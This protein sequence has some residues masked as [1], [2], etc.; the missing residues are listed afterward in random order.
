MITHPRVFDDEWTPQELYHREGAVEVLSEAFDPATQGHAA[1]NVIIHGPSGVGKTVLAKHTMGRLE[2]HA[3]VTTGLIEGLGTTT[4]AVLRR[5]VTVAARDTTPPQNA[6]VEDLRWQLRECIEQPLILVLDE[7][8]G[9]P[10]TDALDQL[11]AIEQLSIVA[12]VH[13]ED[14]WL[15]RISDDARQA[16]AVSI[17]LDRYHINELAAILRARAEKG[18]AESVVT[19]TQLEHIADEVAGVA[20]YGI[21]S[22]HAAA[23]LAA[24]RDHWTIQEQD[25]EGSFARARRRIRRLNLRS[26]PVHHHVLYAL[27]RDAGEISARTLHT[28]YDEIADICYRGTDLMPIGKRER[29]NK[30]QKLREYDL[31]ERDGQTYWVCDAEIPAAIDVPAA[32]SRN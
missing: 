30:L 5:A 14:R 6:T 17:G 16:F 11:L 20:R 23:Q 15:A 24:E 22:L 8:E 21:Q 4:G 9:L 19:D 12:I 25:I 28:R 26:L 29:R 2:Q 27:I 13:D 3:D 10:S 31:I 1:K 7:A 32:E 18:L